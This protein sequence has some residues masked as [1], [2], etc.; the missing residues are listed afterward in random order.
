MFHIKVAR[1]RRVQGC[2]EPEGAGCRAQKEAKAAA[3]KGSSKGKNFNMRVRSWLRINAGGVLNTC[4]SN[5]VRGFGPVLSGGRVSNAWATC[6]AQGDNSWKRL[7]IPHIHVQ[8][9]GSSWKD[10]I[11]AGWARV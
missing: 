11:G 2:L 3:R 10:S 9:H 8:P 6:P 5:G 1:E 7:L 4:K